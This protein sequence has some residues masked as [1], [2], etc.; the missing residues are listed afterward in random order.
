M[1]NVGSSVVQMVFR[2]ET[3]DM[4]NHLRYLQSKGTNEITQQSSSLRLIFFFFCF[5]YYVLKSNEFKRH[6]FETKYPYL[7]GPVSKIPSSL[8]VIYEGIHLT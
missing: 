1:L 8:Y 6:A 2:K 7:I 4:D 3:M 5:S